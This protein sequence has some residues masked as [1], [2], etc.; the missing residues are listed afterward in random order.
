MT[1]ALP[2]QCEFALMAY[3]DVATALKKGDTERMWYALQRWSRRR[4]TSTSC[5]GSRAIRGGRWVSRTTRP[6]AG[7]NFSD[8]QPL[9]VAIAD[10]GERVDSALTQMRV[11]VGT[12]ANR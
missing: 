10:L 2:R 11:L 5:C 8:S 6:W 12:L 3:N 7:P 9:P 4:C 1:Y